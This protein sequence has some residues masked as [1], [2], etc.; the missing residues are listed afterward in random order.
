MSKETY[1]EVFVDPLQ[2]L[3]PRAYGFACDTPQHHQAQSRKLV[4]SHANAHARART[5][6]PAFTPQ[7]PPGGLRTLTF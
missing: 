5:H 2:K 1:L 3:L 6:V 4:N 7:Q